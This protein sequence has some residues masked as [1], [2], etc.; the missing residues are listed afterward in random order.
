MM[1]RLAAAMVLLGVPGMAGSK[2]EI[3]AVGDWNASPADVHKVL[4]SAAMP[5][6]RQFPDRDLSVIKVEP[7]GGPIVLFRRGGEGEYRVRLNTGG[8][9][10]SQYAYQFSHEFCHILCNYKEGGAQNKW[11]EEAICEMAALYS[12]RCMAEDWDTNPPYPN[13]RSYGKA[14]HAYAQDYIDKT[15]VPAD[16]AAWYQRHAGHLS[17]N[18]T[19]RAKNRVLAVTLLPRFE[20][21]PSLWQAVAYLNKG[22]DRKKRDFRRYMQAWYEHAPRKFGPQISGIASLLGV[23]VE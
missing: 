19:D 23:A 16:M 9:F 3:R 17:Q 1:L 5:L 6:W 21:D 20:R 14:L 7:K 2:L 8:T 11:F 18:P 12:L 13:W 15:E 10:W 4:H 22:E